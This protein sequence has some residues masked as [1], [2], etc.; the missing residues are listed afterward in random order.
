LVLHRFL[1][2][3]DHINAGKDGFHMPL[4][5]F[6]SSLDQLPFIDGHD[7]IG[8]LTFG[9]LNCLLSGRLEKRVGLTACFSHSLIH[10]R[11]DPVVVMAG[12][13]LSQ[14]PRV[15]LHRVI[16]GVPSREIG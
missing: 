11:S 13:E 1:S 6:S 14:C 10:E 2:T 4:W 5:D 15:D 7:L 8:R 16:P 3:Q 9:T 12:D